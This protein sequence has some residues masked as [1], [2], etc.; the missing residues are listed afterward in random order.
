MLLLI[1]VVQAMDI[2]LKYGHTHS[3]Q[4]CIYVQSAQ[5]MHIGTQVVT[6]SLYTWIFLGLQT[7]QDS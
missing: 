4:F 6:Y 2:F 1:E 5:N 3:D 7:E